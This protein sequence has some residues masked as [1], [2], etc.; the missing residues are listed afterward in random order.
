MGELT[1]RDLRKNMWEYIINL[2]VKYYDS[3]ET[4]QIMSR[5]IEDSSIV[6]NFISM[7]LPIML[8]QLILF[9][10]LWA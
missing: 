8:S 10:G 2:P 7:K 4:G 5:L 3:K 9:L 6:N 1:I